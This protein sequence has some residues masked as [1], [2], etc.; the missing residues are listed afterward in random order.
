[1]KLFQTLVLLTVLVSILSCGKKPPIEEKPDPLVQ[2]FVINVFNEYYSNSCKFPSLI[3]KKGET[4]TIDLSLSSK[5]WFK[6]SPEGTTPHAYSTNPV[7]NHSF[8]IEKEAGTEVLWFTSDSCETSPS[9]TYDRTPITTS[10]TMQKY[11]LW[12]SD[13]TG[14]YRTQ[15]Q[16]I[17]GYYIQLIAGNPN[18]TIRFQ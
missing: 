13:L 16:V 5:K 15:P 3:L 4:Y 14:I 6:F 12:N 11:E 10:S 9:Y 2:L 7:S 17:K 1:M 8:F 18:I